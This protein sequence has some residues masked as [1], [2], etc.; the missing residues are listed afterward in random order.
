MRICHPNP[1]RSLRDGVGGPKLQNRLT[2]RV[3]VASIEFLKFG[4]ARPGGAWAWAWW[5]MNLCN[6]F[7]QVALFFLFGGGIVCFLAL[8]CDKCQRVLIYDM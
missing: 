6:V 1:S 8:C 5:L 7:P 2:V 3:E 4:L